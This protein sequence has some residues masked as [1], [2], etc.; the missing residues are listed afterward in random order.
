MYISP[1]IC[2]CRYKRIYMYIYMTIVQKRAKID[3][4]ELCASV[5]D[6]KTTN[7][8]RT[9]TGLKHILCVCFR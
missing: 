1:Y 3:I 2:I 5:Y 9:M 6:I 7:C 8:A 4:Y